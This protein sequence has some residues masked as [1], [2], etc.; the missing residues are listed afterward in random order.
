M[1]ITRFRM[2]PDAPDRTGINTEAALGA[3]VCE[4]H[5]MV[6]PDERILGTRIDAE[7]VLAGQA[8]MDTADFRPGVLNVD[9]GHLGTLHTW[10]MCGSAGQHAEPAIRTFAFF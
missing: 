2:Q 5:H 3:L 9:S 8:Y 1:G 10:I 7:P 4:Q 6:F